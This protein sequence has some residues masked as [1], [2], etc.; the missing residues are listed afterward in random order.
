MA[1]AVANG[2]FLSELEANTSDKIFTEWFRSQREPNKGR[3]FDFE[4]DVQAYG[5]CLDREV[6]P[7]LIKRISGEATADTLSW[8]KEMSIGTLATILFELQGAKFRRGPRRS[9]E[10]KDL[11]DML[12][13]VA[14]QAYP[15]QNP[16]NAMVYSLE[17]LHVLPKTFKVE[18]TNPIAYSSRE[19]E[20]LARSVQASF[21]ANGTERYA[22]DGYGDD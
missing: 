21:T 8:P 20:F 12:R 18:L 13:N 22:F 11:K 19:G 2:F 5:F 3:L 15:K 10:Y 9:L 14:R 7:N 4:M 1:I 16:M 17:A 6:D